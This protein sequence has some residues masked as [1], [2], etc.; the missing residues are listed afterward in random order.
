MSEKQYIPGT[1]SVSTEEYRDLITEMT[2][3]KQ[4]AESYRSQKWAAESERNE[5][6]KELETIK[7]KQARLQAFIDSSDEIKMKYKLYLIETS[8]NETATVS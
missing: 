8:Q 6:R 4:N 3:S 7:L 1:V 2:E 5:A